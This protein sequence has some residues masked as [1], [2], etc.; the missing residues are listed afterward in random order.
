ML[1]V[2]VPNVAA[3]PIEYK[4]QLDGWKFDEKLTTGTPC[5][6][7]DPSGQ[8]VNRKLAVNGDA[9][10]D[11]VCYASCAK[12]TNVGTSD[13]LVNDL[14]KVQ[15]SIASDNMNVI[16]SENFEA[17][18]KQITIISLDGK[19][20]ARYEVAPNTQIHNVAVGNFANGLYLLQAKVGVFSQT[21]KVVVNH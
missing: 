8:F 19:I 16:F 17:Q 9:A 2:T 13:V 21:V 10:L 11:V 14:V 15:P 18:T 3:G 4:F 12:C 5:T 20:V 6:I 1:T 7:T